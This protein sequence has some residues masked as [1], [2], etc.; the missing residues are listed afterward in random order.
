M[1][2]SA[3]AASGIPTC[4][5]AKSGI[6]TYKADESEARIF[7]LRLEAKKKNFRNSNPP[8]KAARPARLII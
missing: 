4:K 8:L 5:A 1:M 3:A 2:Q 6:P 7:K